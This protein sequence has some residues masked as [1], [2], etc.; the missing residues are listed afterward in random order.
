MSTALYMYTMHIHIPY[1]PEEQALYFYQFW[2]LYDMLP[3]QVCSAMRAQPTDAILRRDV[4][5][6]LVNLAKTDI[7]S[8]HA[9]AAAGAQ[10]LSHTSQSLTMRRVMSDDL[11]A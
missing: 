9:V 11:K 4:A 1:R 3:R 5:L 8:G 2:R 7:Q 10:E 6:T